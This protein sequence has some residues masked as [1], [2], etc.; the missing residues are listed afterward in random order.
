MNIDNE[1][2]DRI[3][4]IKWFKNCGRKTKY[5][6][7][8]EIV[9]VNTWEQAKSYYSELVWEDTT[10]EAHNRLT[11][12]LHSKYRNEYSKWNSL[13]K[14]TKLFIEKEVTPILEILKEENGLDQIFIDCVKWDIIGA[15]MEESY[16]K[17]KNRPTFFL[18]LLS[19]YEGGN[20]PCGW[21]GEWPDGNLVVF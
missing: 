7:N 17:C 15:I 3:R 16:R 20:Y 4:R 13:I 2:L 14:E 18:T 10:L 12:F 21:E 9:Y 11:E 1:I 19:I 8:F 6:I 5:D